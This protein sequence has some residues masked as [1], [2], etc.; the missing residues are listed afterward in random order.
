MD[1]GINAWLEKKTACCKVWSD[2]AQATTLQEV[3]L[4]G[5]GSSEGS[6]KWVH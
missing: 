6:W 4:I 5:H 1:K 2:L 3:G